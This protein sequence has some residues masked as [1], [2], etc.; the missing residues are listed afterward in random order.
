M[1]EDGELAC[2][3]HR[4]SFPWGSAAAS[5]EIGRTCEGCSRRVLH[6]EWQFAPQFHLRGS[7]EFFFIEPSGLEGIN[8]LE[9]A[10]SDNLIAIE[11]DAFD[12]AGIGVG[13]NFFFL[14]A[15]VGGNN[16]SLSAR[17]EYQGLL[18]LYGRVF[19]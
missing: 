19:F 1:Q 8:N 6:G 14:N 15:E 9:G 18:L 5:G 11:S 4:G 17:Y 13:Y 12:F 3:G 10:L 2:H 7:A 16:P